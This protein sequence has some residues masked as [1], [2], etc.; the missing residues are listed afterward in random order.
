MNVNMNR[1]INKGIY[2][3]SFIFYFKLYIIEKIKHK[4]E[5]QNE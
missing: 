4:G 5:R 3:N 2:K 1:K